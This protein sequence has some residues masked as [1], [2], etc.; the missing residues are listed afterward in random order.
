MM[1]QKCA[2]GDMMYVQHSSNDEYSQHTQSHVMW[3]AE[4]KSLRN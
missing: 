4:F 2:Q 3:G 1:C